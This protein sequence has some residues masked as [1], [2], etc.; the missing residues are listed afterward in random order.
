MPSA[1]VTP[2][3]AAVLIQ[4]R[5]A[6]YSTR[7]AAWRVKLWAKTFTACIL[8]YLPLLGI[9]FES[10]MTALNPARSTFWLALLAAAVVALVAIIEADISLKRMQQDPDG[11]AARLA[12]RLRTL[13]GSGWMIR[14]ASLGVFPGVGLGLP[15]A[16]LNASRTGSPLESLPYIA[17]FVGLTIAWSVPLAFVIRYGYLRA[18]FRHTG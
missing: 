8:I 11:A 3:R 7:G 12:S 14:T 9:R 1:Y 4:R 5:V 2:G 16:L 6:A 17:R 10:T 18:W 13:T 15:V